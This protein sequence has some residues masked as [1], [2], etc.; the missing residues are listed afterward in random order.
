MVHVSFRVKYFR[1]WPKTMDY[2][3][4]FFVVL[5]LLIGR[6]NEAEICTILL[7]LT[8]T[9]AKYIIIY[10]AFDFNQS[11][12]TIYSRKPCTIV[13]GLDRY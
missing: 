9:F 11:Q 3:S 6:C 1:C 5:L 8:C 2:E 10:I 12:I 13:R 7:P 4:F